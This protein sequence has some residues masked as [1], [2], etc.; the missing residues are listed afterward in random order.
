MLNKVSGRALR[1]AHTR[2]LQGHGL[3]GG[4]ASHTLRGD[5]SVAVQSLTL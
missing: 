1:Q 5:P 4:W 2:D 3:G